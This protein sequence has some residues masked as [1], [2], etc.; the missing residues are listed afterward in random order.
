MT[1]GSVKTPL[2]YDPD[3]IDVIGSRKGIRDIKIQILF[4]EIDGIINET[5]KN[6]LCQTLMNC[7]HIGLDLMGKK[8]FFFARIMKFIKSWMIL[9]NRF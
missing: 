7:Y 9:R 8:A 1:A 5:R 6:I 3:L 4:S 2:D